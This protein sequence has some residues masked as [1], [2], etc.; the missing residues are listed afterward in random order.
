MSVATAIP[1]GGGRT[2]VRAPAEKIAFGLAVFIVLTFSQSWMTALGSDGK[3]E[4]GFIRVLY[5]PAY[6]CALAL[7]AM[8]P[9]RVLSAMVRTPLL[10]VLMGVVVASVSW[11]IDPGMT[12]RRAVAVIFT[13]L[14]GV[15]IASRYDWPELMEV[16]ATAFGVLAVGSL[17]VAVAVPGFGVMHE[18]FPGAWRGLWADK[19]ALGGYMAQGFAIFVSAAVLNPRHRLRWAGFAC[20][21]F[22]L[23]LASTSKTS[24]VALIL[25][26]GAITFVA[27]VK[28]GP[29][30]AVAATFLAMVGALALACFI[31][32]AS[33]V[34]FALLGKDATLTGRTA[35]WAGIIR[36]VETRPWTGFGYGVV[37]SDRSGW[38]P[39]AWISHDAKFTAQHAHNSWLETWLGVGYIG[40]AVWVLLFVETWVKALWAAYTNPGGWFAAPFLVIYTISTMTESVAFIYHDFI[41]VM[42]AI[43]ASRLA[44]PG[45]V[46]V[47]ATPKV[48]QDMGGGLLFPNRDLSRWAPE[49]PPHP[50][51]R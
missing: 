28:R 19:N 42:F 43:I 6:L 36:Q 20:L 34:F 23:V 50:R 21:A 1:Q 47:D 40:L 18:I 10:W 33:D 24:L 15:V 17:F 41:W 11:S 8:R 49:P 12:S 32:F 44:M 39:Y 30:M 5:F 7:V 25:G 45:S 13:T 9:E 16:M 14:G 35:I 31:V 51:W 29:A 4:P 26:L 48:E 46:A 22:L 27:L 38:G 2:E 3:S 37:W